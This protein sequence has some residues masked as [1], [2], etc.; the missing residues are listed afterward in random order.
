MYSIVIL[1]F[2]FCVMM[3]LIKLG[4]LS[5]VHDLDRT[6]KLLKIAKN[7][8]KE[9]FEAE[10]ILGR[11]LGYPTYDPVLF[12]DADGDVCTG[13][14]T[15]VTLALEAADLIANLDTTDKVLVEI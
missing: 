8:L 1:L 2:G 5:S 9:L 6:N 11:A 12:P 15:V 10:Q 14:N 13:E 3:L 7:Q 4:M